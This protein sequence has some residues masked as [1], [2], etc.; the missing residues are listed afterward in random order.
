MNRFL[1]LL[2]VAAFTVSAAAQTSASLAADL[3]AADAAHWPAINDFGVKLRDELKAA[4]VAQLASATA[5]FKT[6]LETANA[7]RAD[8]ETK[9]TELQTRITNVLSAT[10]A[11][12]QSQLVTAQTTLTA[13]LATG[14]GP[15]AAAK[16]LV[17]TDLQ[18]RIDTV[19]SLQSEASKSDRQKAVKAAIAAKSA[20][21]KALADAQAALEK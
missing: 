6:K 3:Q 21:D 5:D 15:V 9:L 17:V 1:T 8:A 14:D 4:H 10:L 11:D 13:E 19:Q 12:L 16:R 7:A 20:A 18:A 2:A